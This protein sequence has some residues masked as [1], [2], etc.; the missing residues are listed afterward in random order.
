MSDIK[1]Q[2]LG[3]ETP[4]PIQASQIDTVPWSHEGSDATV[5]FATDELT[6]FCPATNQPDF[7]ELK[8]S[9]VPKKHLLE[10]KAMKLYLWSFRDKGAFA[11]D[12]A[13][14][15][16]DDLVKACGPVWMEVDLTQKVRGGLQI[17]T[18]VRHTEKPP[19]T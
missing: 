11:E 15:L 16:L 17:R 14:T 6:A 2:F 5:E 18:V 7:Y 13:A 3:Q 10:S 4:G 19:E 8:L 9:Y 12:L 1:A